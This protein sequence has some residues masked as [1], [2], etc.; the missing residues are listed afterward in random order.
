MRESD[1]VSA[2]AHD[3]VPEKKHAA[4]RRCNP[5]TLTWA[6]NLNTYLLHSH[7]YSAVAAMLGG[8][9]DIYNSFFLHG[10]FLPQQWL[11]DKQT[12]LKENPWSLST[13]EQKGA[14]VI[15]D[16]FSRLHLVFSGIR[17]SIFPGDIRLIPCQYFAAIR[18]AIIWDAALISNSLYSI[19]WLTIE[20]NRLLQSSNK[21]VSSYVMPNHLKPQP[22]LQRVALTVGTRVFWLLFKH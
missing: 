8:I 4:V 10:L 20:C 2:S 6:S 21:W 11:H 5:L 17:L 19:F 18:A 3:R 15:P 1:K 9:S 12:S 13:A 7:A 22:N 16:A 14:W